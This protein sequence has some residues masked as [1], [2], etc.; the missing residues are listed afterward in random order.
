VTRIPEA[1]VAWLWERRQ[2]HGTLR[3]TDG[4]AVQVI[5]PGWRWGSWGPD[6][7]GALLAIDGIVAR[8]DVEIHVR[9]QD[10]D[11][12]GHA[13]DP[14]YGALV[15]HVV[16]ESAPASP[17]VRPDGA[18]V[19]TACLESLLDDP[20]DDALRG[21]QTSEGPVPPRPCLSPEAAIPVLE[22][23][24]LQRF[25]A[26][27]G[28]F[29]ADLTCVD[30]EQALWAGVLEALGYPRNAEPFRQIADRVSLVEARSLARRGHRVELLALLFGEAGLLPFQ[31]DL[32]PPD[33]YAEQME[34]AWHTAR[35]HR[36]SPALVWQRVGGRP[37]NTPPRRIAAAAALL[38]DPPQWPVARQ[39]FEKL[40]QAPP[41][42]VAATLRSFLTRAGDAYWQA[43][44][45]FGRP[46]RRPSALLGPCRA[47]DAVVNA[48]LPWAA[49]LARSWDR[50]DLERAVES[51][52][53]AHPPVSPN[54]VTRH[55][56][57]Q[58]LGA[59]AHIAL[60]TACRQQGLIHIYRTSCDARD[61]AACAA[62]PSVYGEP[63]LA[64]LAARAACC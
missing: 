56:A 13:G 30:P 8:G 1:F 29:K 26:K 14:A 64:D 38:A 45:D 52:Y 40:A 46:T 62:R 58:I 50:P 16:Y 51:G 19:P 61:C 63:G 9:A 4:R 54:H 31:R 41:R 57:E 55:M 60:T 7:R 25:R 28:R 47:G 21:W 5:Y 59:D 44:V 53:R 42:R 33:Y 15:L 49:A 36:A 24:G 39:V 32:P 17:V 48:V 27:V 12:H 20:I 10:W 23:A 2:Y 22:H 18:M 35:V 3:T 34:R 43:H 11:R 6:F 37:A